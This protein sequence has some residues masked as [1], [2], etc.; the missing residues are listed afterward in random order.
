MKKDRKVLR[1]VYNSGRERVRGFGEAP[2]VRG[3]GGRRRAI[4]MKGVKTQSVPA[5]RYR[6]R[7]RSRGF[8][9]EKEIRRVLDDHVS[10][11]TLGGAVGYAPTVPVKDF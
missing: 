10:Q 11:D 5:M 4:R 2:E 3:C 9:E 6:S 1:G 7:E 8:R